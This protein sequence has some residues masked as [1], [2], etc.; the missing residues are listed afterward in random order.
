M[1]VPQDSQTTSQTQHPASELKVDSLKFGVIF[2]L[3]LTAVQRLLE[4][5]RGVLF[6]RFLPE[7]Q[8]GQ[9][10]LTWSYLILIAALRSLGC[11][12]RSTDTWRCIVNKGSCDRF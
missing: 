2:A 8:L 5:V 11:R 1:S 9:W 3:L 4:L 12:A 10:S 6:C 7:D